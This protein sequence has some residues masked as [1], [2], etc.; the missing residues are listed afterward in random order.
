MKFTLTLHDDDMRPYNVVESNDFEDFKIKVWEYGL[1]DYNS[2]YT[3][4]DIIE[5]C[6]F[7]FNH[8][9][10]S[11]TFDFRPTPWV[12]YLEMCYWIGFENN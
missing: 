11:I 4:E 10:T 3:L 8:P 12:H 1:H 7:C 6:N 9:N 2:T 5:F